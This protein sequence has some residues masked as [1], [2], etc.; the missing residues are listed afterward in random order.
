[1][2]AS[3]FRTYVRPL[4]EYAGQI[5]HSGL[6]KDA[7]TLE[8]VQR[9]GTKMVSG[10]R[11]TP[12]ANRLQKLGMFPLEYRR[13][14]GDLILLYFLFNT[15]LH[16]KLFTLAPSSSRRG[17]SK[18]IFKLRPRTSLRNNFFT[19]RVVD[20]WNNLPSVIV[21]AKNADQFKRLL[22]HHMAPHN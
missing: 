3:L 8:K 14:R 11:N 7:S 2:F 10:L 9:R 22:D 5:V 12:Y 20:L 4:L 18:K 13:I 17:H 16:T 21:N 1:M 19:F 6:V 15:G